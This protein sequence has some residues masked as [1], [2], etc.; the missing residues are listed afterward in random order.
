MEIYSATRAVRSPGNCANVWAFFFMKFHNSNNVRKYK[1]TIV[2][3][4]LSI[5]QILKIIKYEKSA[6]MKNQQI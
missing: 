4:E 5:G 1:F 3:T 6:N 2:N